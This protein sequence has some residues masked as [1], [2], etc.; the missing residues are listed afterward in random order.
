MMDKIGVL[1]LIIPSRTEPDLPVI[2]IDMVYISHHPFASCN[3]I[4]YRPAAGVIEIEVPPAIALRHPDDFITILAIA[5]KERG[6]IAKKGL[7]LLIHHNAGFPG[8]CFHFNDALALMPPLVILIRKSRAVFLPP[9][10]L[11]LIRIRQK[12]FIV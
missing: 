12:R 3:L 8:L 1:I 5:P 11:F 7:R 10:I 2:P 6:G 4:L 9:I